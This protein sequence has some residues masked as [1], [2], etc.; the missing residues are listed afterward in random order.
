MAA[1]IRRTETDI[2]GEEAVTDSKYN[3][4][5]QTLGK[6]QVTL[7][8]INGEYRSTYDI[9]SD[10]ADVWDQ[11][12]SMEQ[13]ALAETIAGTRNQN[14]FFSM[15]EQ[16]QEARGAVESM[17]D[18][19]GAMSD[20][21]G[22]YLDSIEGKVGQLKATFETLS[23]DFIRSGTI[24]GAVDLG[25][26]ILGVA[27]SL[28]KVNMLLPAAIAG[29]GA[30]KLA[31]AAIKGKGILDSLVKSKTLKDLFTT[32][33]I[34]SMISGGSVLGNI[35]GAFAPAIL[36]VAGVAA[37]GIGAGV[38]INN[39][40]KTYDKA[41]E[42]ASV[43]TQEYQTQKDTVNRLNKELDTT[44]DRID[45]LQSKGSLTTVE[46]GELAKLRE[47]QT[48]LEQQASIAQTL[49]DYKGAEA[50]N[51]ARESLYAKG[52]TL[53]EDGSGGKNSFGLF[54]S[55]LG[56]AQAGIT[57]ETV[58]ILSY[59]EK[60][61]ESLNKLTKQR[62]ELLNKQAEAQGRNDETA[63][64]N[65]QKQID[66]LDERISETMTDLGNVMQDIGRAR[67]GLVDDTGRV[68]RPLMAENLRKMAKSPQPIK[69][70]V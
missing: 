62:T 67:E 40:V 23:F 48:I 37:A 2:E 31:G 24:K 44:Q 41:S 36:G 22:I 66:S 32:A 13:S 11:M 54:L 21:Y 12:S 39:W 15:V 38:A 8:D 70:L 63:V 61:Q 14:V 50:A 56:A 47:Q 3:E 58:D 7:T 33:K 19:G 20:A 29:F 46:E 43:A 69:K 57:A 53:L 27:D 64:E 9:V 18:A 49:A 1:R 25:T 42:K 5:V 68:L 65:Y 10:I 6:H 51:S 35:F 60:K 45:E 52:F 55:K 4:M 59:A 26:G 30:I 28:A 17:Q 34:D 16:F